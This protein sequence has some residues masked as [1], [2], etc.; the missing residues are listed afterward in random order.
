MKQN[1][2]ILGSPRSGTTF[3]ASL[4]RPTAYGSPFETQ[5]ILKYHNK[6]DSYGDITQLCN[7]TRLINDI[8]KERAI[9]QWGVKFNPEVVKGDLGDKFSYTELV[10]YIC[11]QLMKKKGKSMW[12]D[13][14]PHYILKL[15]QLVNLYPNAKYLYI[16]RDGR[17]VALSL[18]K[19]PWGPNNIYKCAEQWA[20]A[21]NSEQ[22]LLLTALKDKG[23]LLYIKYEELLEKTEQECRRIYEFLGDDIENHRE[24]VDALI[25]KTMSGNH[26]KWKTQMTSQQI[27]IYEAT[28]KSSLLYHNYELMDPE[29]QL[30]ALK[31]FGYKL[32]HQLLFLKHMFVMNVIDGLKIKFLG[33]QPFNE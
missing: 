19:K 3:L 29:S 30:S 32:H 11:T 1:L 9:A 12:G 22:Q 23:Q 27:S 6:L 24:M 18:L 16:V 26:A 10:D 25:A 5:F 33:K 28:A 21:N 7:L 2:F 20:A 4:L 13:K 31:V 14:T 15:N 17:D 8:S